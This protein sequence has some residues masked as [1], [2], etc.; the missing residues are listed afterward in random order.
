[1]SK[2]PEK[3]AMKWRAQP[4]FTSTDCDNHL[5]SLAEFIGM[6]CL[7]WSPAGWE[8]ID[9]TPPQFLTETEKARWTEEKEALDTFVAG[10]SN[11]RRILAHLPTYMIFDDHD[12]TDD[13]NLTVGWE[14]AAYSHPFSRIIIGNGLLAYWLCQGWGNAP[15]NFPDDWEQMAGSIYSEGQEGFA[16]SAHHHQLIDTLYHFNHWHYAVE[17]SPKI[18]VMDTRTNAGSQNP[19]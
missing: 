11:V 8:N 13:W 12:V 3:R 1:M 10:L 18:L 5:I 15:E 7:V 19:R 9:L 14:Q 17:T 6:Y 16:S 4:V 2:V